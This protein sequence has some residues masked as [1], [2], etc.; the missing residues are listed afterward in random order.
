MIHQATAASQEEAPVDER[1]RLLGDAVESAFLNI[2]DL[3]NCQGAWGETQQFP[4]W[5]GSIWVHVIAKVGNKDDLKELATKLTAWHREFER[6]GFEAPSFQAA[7]REAR[8]KI[9]TP[10]KRAR[11]ET[12]VRSPRPPSLRKNPMI[13]V[14]QTNPKRPGS[15]SYDRYELYKPA[16]SKFQF[17]HLGGSTADYNHDLSKGYITEIPED[18][19]NFLAAT[20]KTEG[21]ASPVVVPQQPSFSPPPAPPDGATQDIGSSDRPEHHESTPPPPTNPHPEE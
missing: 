18:D 5:L 13:S 1:I 9:N 12:P 19:D 11:D 20:P 6:F 17:L 16:T 8:K 14:R 4:E 3:D 7:S 21:A 10:M 2:G 15:K